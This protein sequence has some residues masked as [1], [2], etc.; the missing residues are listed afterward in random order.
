MTICH[1]PTYQTIAIYLKGCRHVTS[2]TKAM[3]LG[4]KKNEAHSR[5]SII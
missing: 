3:L 5:I 2:T 1:S 4:K